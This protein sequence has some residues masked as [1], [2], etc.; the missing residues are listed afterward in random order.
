MLILT[1][2]M[3]IKVFISLKEKV[4]VLRSAMVWKDNLSFLY[5]FFKSY[6]TLPVRAVYSKIVIRYEI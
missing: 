6:E 2:S 1:F 3:E 4:K 5:Y